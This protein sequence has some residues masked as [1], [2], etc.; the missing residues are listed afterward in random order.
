MPVR[1]EGSCR[2][3]AVAFTVDSHTPHPF[4]RCYCGICRKIG[5]GGGYA[6]NIMGVARTLDVSGAA[7][8]AEVSFHIDGVL[9][10][11]K[12]AFCRRCG[13]ALWGFH[14]EWPDAVY[15]FASAIDTDLP[16]PPAT[17]HIMLDHKASWVVPEIREGDLTF[18]RYPVQSIADWHSSRGLWVD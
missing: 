10:T 8:K 16:V 7:E 2:C 4:M 13:C 6:I 15:P 1:L 12:R 9:S 18:E 5:G 14:P 3:G 17:T 11:M